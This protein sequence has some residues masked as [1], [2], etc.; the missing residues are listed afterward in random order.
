MQMMLLN[1]TWVPL[2]GFLFIVFAFFLLVL[3]L[4]LI[5]RLTNTRFV[6]KTTVIEPFKTLKEIK[7][8]RIRYEIK[9]EIEN[10]R[11]EWVN[12]LNTFCSEFSMFDILNESKNKS[13]ESKH[14]DHLLSLY[15]NFGSQKPSTAA[16]AIIGTEIPLSEASSILESN[17]K[18]VEVLRVYKTLKEKLKNKEITYLEYCKLGNELYNKSIE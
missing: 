16:W 5:G 7:E 8:E 13:E 9:N 11:N 14:L 1:N 4:S 12:E 2:F 17:G 15:S 3:I 6:Y 10:K 18:T